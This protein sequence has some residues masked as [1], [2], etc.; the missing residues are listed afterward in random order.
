MKKIF[1]FLMLFMASCLIIGMISLPKD[2]IIQSNGKQSFISQR[3]DQNEISSISKIN[4]NKDDLK[5]ELNPIVM[6]VTR[7]KHFVPLSVG[8][9]FG[10][11]YDKKTH[12]SYVLTNDHICENLIKDNSLIITGTISYHQSATISPYDYNME[13]VVL[14]SSPEH[15]LCLLKWQG[16]LDFVKFAKE[17]PGQFDVLTTVGAPHGNFPIIQKAFFSGYLSRDELFD[18]ML[19]PN[20][21][22]LLLSDIFFGGSSGSPVFNE[23][24]EVVG[25]I[26]AKLHKSTPYGPR[27]S[28]G[29]I[30]IQ[31]EEIMEFFDEIGFKL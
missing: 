20:H 11:K 2:D 30:A 9:G 4:K 27:D 23:D 7:T 12:E 31:T 21:S 19:G 6:L 28:Y 14:E 29:G 3:M 16:H 13:L 17:R 24:K 1:N 26:F 22:Y 15:D 25:I 10:I 8:T 18:S 5:A